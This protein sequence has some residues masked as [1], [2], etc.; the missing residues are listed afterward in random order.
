M[1]IELETG[2]RESFAFENSKVKINGSTGMRHS[3]QIDMTK[4]NIHTINDKLNENSNLNSVLST[5]SSIKVVDTTIDK[6]D[7]NE[8]KMGQKLDLNSNDILDDKLILAFDWGYLKDKFEIDISLFLVDEKGKSSDDRFYFYGNKVAK[9]QSIKLSDDLGLNIIQSFD[10]ILS[11]DL[12]KLDSDVSR[13]AITAT[14]YDENRN[15]GELNKGTVCFINNQK[16]EFLNYSFTQNLKS[17]TAI[18]ICEIYKHNGKWKV[19][20]IGQG[21]NGGLGALC[22]NFGIE[23]T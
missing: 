8:L 1:K 22:N 4:G 20:G 10:S 7:S 9:N 2:K 18:V 13:I 17:E 19:Q 5:N 12:K 6:S 11:I 14:L 3:G 21:F 23:T 15:F 16:K